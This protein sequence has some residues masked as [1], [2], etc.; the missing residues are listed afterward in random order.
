MNTD[1]VNWPGT[2]IFI[3]V[4]LPMGII[5]TVYPMVIIKMLIWWPRFILSRLYREGELRPKTR[6]ALDLIDKDPET[7]AAKTWPQVWSIRVSGVILLLM[8]CCSFT[9]VIAS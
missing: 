5:A 6:L 9:G 2:V 1:I 4:A 7:Y 3:I 8:A